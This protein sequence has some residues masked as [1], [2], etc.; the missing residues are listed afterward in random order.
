MMRLYFFKHVF[1]FLTE[2]LKINNFVKLILLVF[3]S[4]FIPGTA[5]IFVVKIGHG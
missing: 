4:G 1:T 3:V 5:S 2:Y